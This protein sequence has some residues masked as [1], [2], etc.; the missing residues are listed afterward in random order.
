MD[1][2]ETIFVKEGKLENLTLW[3]DSRAGGN[4]GQT[5]IA[6]SEYYGLIIVANVPVRMLCSAA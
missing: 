3:E 4:R 2:L 6:Q 5:N 1:L